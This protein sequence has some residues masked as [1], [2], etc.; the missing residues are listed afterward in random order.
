M[1]SKLN[2]D[3]ILL[4]TPQDRQFALDR[5]MMI[6]KSDY[7]I[8]IEYERYVGYLYEK[9]GYRVQ[10]CG[11]VM[12]MGDLGR[13]L[14]VHTDDGIKVIQC[15]RWAKDKLI[16]EKYIH[17]LFGTV[18]Q[19]RVQRGVSKIYGVIYTTSQLSYAARKCAKELGIEICEKQPF[20]EYPR[21]KCVV[22][23]TG[24]RIYYLP[25]DRGYDSVSVVYADEGKYV[26]DILEAEESGFRWVN[27]REEKP[28]N[29]HISQAVKIAV[30]AERALHRKEIAKLLLTA[31]LTNT[32]TGEPIKNMDDFWA[33][34]KAF[35]EDVKQRN[36][37]HSQETYLMIETDD[38]FTVRVPE[39]KL[40]SWI[41]AQDKLKN[42]PLNE[43]EQRLIDKAIKKLFGNLDEKTSQDDKE[44]TQEDETQNAQ[45][46]VEAERKQ[47][48]TNPFLIAA[49]IISVCLMI[50]AT[51]FAVDYHS[52]LKMR[53]AG[54]ESLKREHFADLVSKN[55]EIDELHA[56][57]SS[58]Y[59]LAHERFQEIN[60]MR[61][62]FNF[63]R[64]YAAIVITEESQ[65]HHY[66]C[67]HIRGKDFFIY[68]IELAKSYGHTPCLD[69]WDEGLQSLSGRVLSSDELR[70]ILG[71]G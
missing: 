27:C 34:K 55:T 13:D 26:A 62:E 28:D 50:A 47:S 18:S 49:L 59:K 71:L 17:Q 60:D 38:G 14:I 65:Y 61:S 52:R 43:A 3:G 30:E 51:A 36:K 25:F 41:E 23:K 4:N 64:N 12:G 68:N 7:E 16:H 57:L 21:I 1:D 19:M 58:A 32:V 44:E 8:G 63:M 40:D 67:N 2:F 37:E 54:I 42:T 33:W 5:Y 48:R 53:D 9:Q 24:K 69:C 56:E 29:S 31:Q 15:K 35:D 22:S 11:A 66:G 20:I 39:S 45:I 6:K 10:F 46:A 70:D